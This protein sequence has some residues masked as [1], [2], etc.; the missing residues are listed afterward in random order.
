MRNYGYWATNK[1][2]APEQGPQIDSVRD[3][4]L[5]HVTN[6]DFRGFDVSYPDVKRVDAF[7]KDLAEFEKSGT[8][9]SFMIMRLGNDHTFGAEPGKTTPLACFADNDY[10]LGMIVEAVS[11]SI[12]WRNTAIFVLEDD[13]QNGPDHIDSHR[14]LAFVISPYTRRGIID[15]TMYNTTSM[16]RT[17]ELILKMRPMTHFDAGARPMFNAFGKDA[18]M[19][20]YVAEKPRIPLD[21]RNPAGAPTAATTHHLD[22]TE[23]DLND[24]DELNDILWRTIRKS[25]PPPVRQA[26]VPVLLSHH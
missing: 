16:L 1:K 14:S 17:M 9:P 4:I 7:V 23:A 20:P 21:S 11:R 22:F 10:A 19:T 15:S 25:D 6:M 5:A 2:P 18:V 24:E 3:P 12:F 13:A 26:F 8:M